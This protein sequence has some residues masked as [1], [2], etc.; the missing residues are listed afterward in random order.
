MFVVDSAPS[1]GAVLDQPETRAVG[2]K[3]HLTPATYRGAVVA[4]AVL[5][6]GLAATFTA[7]TVTERMMA[8]DMRQ[9]FATD[10]AATTDAIGQR[11]RAHGEVLVSMQGLYASVGR[12]D[13]AQFRRY[14][15]VLDLE[16][17][18][19]GF[20][21]LQALRHVQPAD[22]D[23]FI[24]EVRSDTSL[25]PRGQPGFHVHPEGQRRTYSVVELVEPLQGNENSVGFDAGANP[26]QLDSLR[27]AAES[28]RIVATP[29]VKLVQDTSGGQG[30]IL[31]APIYRVGEPVQ[32]VAQR[33]AALRGYVAA[34]YRVNDLM[35]GVLDARTLQQMH[36][37]IVDRGYA[38]ATPEGV[39]TDEPEDPAGVATL[40]YDSLEAN[41]RLVTPVAVSA[42]G[43]SAERAL[44]VGERVWMLQFAARPGSTYEVDRMAPNV[45][46]ASGSIISALL[47]L[48]SLTVMRSRRLS[49]SLETLDAEQRALVE[50]PLAGILFTDGRRVLR[51]NRR[52]AELCDI[53]AEK[54]AGLDIETLLVEPRDI[55]AFEAAL[56]KIRASGAAGVELNMRRADGSTF[57]VDA[58]GRPLVA[59]GRNGRGDIL[60]VIQDKTDALLVEAER[61][62]HAS[63]LQDANERLTASLHA[64]E[65]RTKEIALLTELSGVLQSCHKLEEVFAAVQSYASRLFPEEAGALYVL[66]P[67]RDLATRGARWGEPVA[68]SASFHPDLCWALRRGQTFPT[69]EASRGLVCA[70]I[71]GC[72]ET[73]PAGFVCQPLIAQ[74]NLLGL[75]YRERGEAACNEAAMQLATMLS[76]QVSLA[77]ANIELREQLRS[78]AL[79]DPLTGLHNRRFLE[80]ALSQEI[81]RCTRSGKPLSLAILDIDHFKRINDTCSHEAGDAVLRELGDILRKQV[82]KSDVVGR[83]GGEE[84]LLLLPEVDL[85]TALKRMTN[86]LDAVRGMSVTWQG[87]VLDD[88]TASIGVAVMPL[89]V[90][91]GQGLFAAADAALYRAK[92]QG[93]NCIVVSD[94]VAAP[95][96]APL[97]G[98]EAQPSSRSIA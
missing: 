45:V 36:I 93:R 53:A 4:A 33:H 52:I 87:G 69:S 74:N 49:G 47:A 66:N 6:A 16:R 12:V 89:H 39:M 1:S 90:E 13:R 50:N 28:G 58:Y 68:D 40:M 55:E 97:E 32:T 64:A 48:L 70:H 65:A 35:R 25:D 98:A 88:I 60:W 18:Y 22:L 51:G 17:R 30:F 29:P 9:R 19:P 61:R 5:V 38:K 72:C 77:I 23:S 3:D 14:V 37:R 20:Q 31:R 46:L 86:L 84:F 43:I 44:V 82:R 62:D 85:E 76:E 2:I 41:L 26:L 34:V 10:A 7:R 27:R 91:D 21:A 15:D 83:L 78:Q 67:A 95:L 92:S 63:K 80:E 81:A 42:L 71:S 56:G 8:A 73:P 57:P 24:A 79:R 75:L 59:G 96:L 54:L 11:L 94:K